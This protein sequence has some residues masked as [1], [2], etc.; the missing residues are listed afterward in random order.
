MRNQKQ[1]LS[2][3]LKFFGAEWP[4]AYAQFQPNKQGL[5]EQKSKPYTGQPGCFGFLGATT[6]RTQFDMSAPDGT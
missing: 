4:L 3:D 5:S 2:A 1:T 6:L